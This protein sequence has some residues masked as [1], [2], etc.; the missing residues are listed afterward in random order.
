VTYAER[1]GGVLVAPRRALRAAARSGGGLR[2]VGWLMVARL[3]CGEAPRLVR[4]AVRVQLGV[5]A[6]LGDL[7]SVLSTVLPDVTGV[8]L[9]AVVLSLLGKRTGAAIDLAAYAW[10]PYLAVELVGA[11]AFSAL[12]R[13]PS[14]WERRALDGGAL[15]WALAVWIVALLEL[16]ALDEERVHP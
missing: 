10:V 14:L 2:D 8:L 3:V 5:D 15:A 4:A 12:G 16:R 13:A 1:I 6:A 7:L 9:A 11:L